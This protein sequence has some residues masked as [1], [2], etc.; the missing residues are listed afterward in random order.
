MFKH[1]ATLGNNNHILPPMST[2]NNNT[3]GGSRNSSNRGGMNAQYSLTE[4][5]GSGA[6]RGLANSSGGQT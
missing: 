5:F 1:T 4:N 3:M 6:L 2:K